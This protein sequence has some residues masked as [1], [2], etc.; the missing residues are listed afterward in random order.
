MWV[1]DKRQRRLT[2]QGS[3]VV[4]DTQHTST[5]RTIEWTEMSREGSKKGGKEE[6]REGGGGGREGRGG[7]G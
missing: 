7:R 1:E 4:W 5:V 2:H 6:G 3:V